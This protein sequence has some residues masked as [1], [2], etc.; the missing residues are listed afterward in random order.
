MDANGLGRG[1]PVGFLVVGAGPTGVRRA[2]AVAATPGA[3]LVATQDADR[4]YAAALENDTVDAVVIASPHARHFEQ[5]WGALE[6]GKHVLC[7]A[8]LA[9]RPRQAR[10]LAARADELGR[11]LATGLPARFLAPIRD[12]RALLTAWR[13][14]RVERVRVAV[15]RRTSMEAG[16]TACDL[17]RRFLGDVV[18]VH[19]T[20]DQEPGGGSEALAVFRNHDGVLAEVRTFR[21]GSERGGLTLD[22]YGTQGRLQ[23]G[24]G[25]WSLSCTRPGGGGVCRRYLAERI[26]E[27]LFRQRH[28]CGRALALETQAFV[29]AIK[30]RRLG[31]D[32]ASGWDGARVTEMLDAVHRAH[33]AGE[34]VPVHAPPAPR[35]GVA[36]QAVAGARRVA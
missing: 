16:L 24:A 10:L 8:P 19:G 29:A 23:V 1:L 15:G 34:E 30:G 20:R 3:R 31:R 13:I 22:V 27:R 25:G 28:G 35:L 5:A 32:E 6:A 14:G 7:E 12:A 17:V 18:A 4:G 36:R 33:Q 9:L 26:A 11:V 21:S 2:A